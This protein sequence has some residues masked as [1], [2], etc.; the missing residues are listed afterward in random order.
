V[1]LIFVTKIL[2]MGL[3]VA[4]I[5]IATVLFDGGRYAVG[6]T[7]Q[8]MSVELQGLVRLFLVIL[9]IE[10]ASLVGNYY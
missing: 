2:M 10:A 8:G 7:R 3:A 1:A 5:P 4:V 6:P 9:L